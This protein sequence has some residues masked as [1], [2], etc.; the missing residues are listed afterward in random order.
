MSE[1]LT[2]G[3]S[4]KTAPVDVRERLALGDAAATEFLSDLAAEPAIREAVVIS[5]CNRTEITV[6]VG[7][8]VAA[9]SEL[10]GWLA[11]RAGIR[12]TELGK[13]MYSP[14]NCDAARQ[15]FRVT[16]GLESM[17][18][19]EAEV[20]GQVKRSYETAL[21]AGT[22][23]PLTNR[24]FTAALQ[25]GKRVRTETKISEGHASVSSVAVK[26]AEDT[27]GELAARHVVIIGAGETSELTTRALHARGVTTMFVANRHADR[28]RSLAERF[29]GDVVALDRLPDQ[30]EQADIVVSQ[31]ASPHAIID[32]ETLE[33]VMKARGGRELL[34]I[35]IAVPRDIDPACADIPGVTLF[36]V[37]DLQSVVRRTTSVREIEARR[38][39]DIVEDEIERFAEWLGSRAVLPTIAAL[40]QQGTEI[41]EQVLGEN[42]GRW[43]SASPADIAR[44]EA[45]AR[46]VM[47]RL[48]HE[49]TIRLK[50]SDPNRSHGRLSLVRELFGMDEGA[51][52]DVQEPERGAEVRSLPR[53]G[54]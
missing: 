32:Q 45:I 50:G 4:H 44:V 13:V 12:P 17:I 7:D 27:L 52:V 19:G 20:Q 5:T 31:T 18:V 21:G 22:A 9:E 41:V 38:A 48:L 3:I 28:A 36:D 40:R 47:N 33:L 39:E 42:E 23:G 11:K 49:P 53:R 6:V 37:D 30:L 8:P 26:L 35:D 29:G 1:L 54:A 2:L 25:T 46:A 16:S 10:L 43:E 14:R 24:L 15:L 34:L 51:T